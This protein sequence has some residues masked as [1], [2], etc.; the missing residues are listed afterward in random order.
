MK[1]VVYIL[2]FVFALGLT[3]NLIANNAG[4]TQKTKIS[5]VDQSPDKKPCPANCT[6]ECCK[7]KEAK[8]DAKCDKKAEKK[9]CPKAKSCDKAKSA[10]S[11]DSKGQKTTK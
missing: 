2:S 9:C 8:A 1:K 6:K 10:K 4:E 3:V 5:V 11:E 7:A